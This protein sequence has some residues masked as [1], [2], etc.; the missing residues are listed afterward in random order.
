MTATLSASSGRRF[1]NGDQLSIPANRLQK[2]MEW[3]GKEQEIP[4]KIASAIAATMWLLEVDAFRAEEEKFMLAG[5][6]ESSLLNHRVTLSQLIADGEKVVFLA[7]KNGMTLTPAGF[8]LKDLQ[9]TLTS[10][11]T[12]FR[13]EYGPKNPPQTAELIERLLNA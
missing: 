3:V 12:T 5:E 10:L 9:S 2:E 11:H 13:G 7:Q 1:G 8:D 4:P 6:Y